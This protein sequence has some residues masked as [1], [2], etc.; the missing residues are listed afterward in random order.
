MLPPL[1][2]WPIPVLCRG[3]RRSFSV[4]RRTRRPARRVPREKVSLLPSL[5][6]FQQRDER[7]SLSCGSTVLHALAGQGLDPPLQGQVFH[8]ARH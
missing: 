3:E 8:L 2:T 5:K 4:V 6:R 1:S 7:P